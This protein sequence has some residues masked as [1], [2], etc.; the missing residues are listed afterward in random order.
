MYI[1]KDIET[2]LTPKLNMLLVNGRF[3]EPEADGLT[4]I[5]YLPSAE[6]EATIR[7]IADGITT[8]V[9]IEDNEQELG[10]S[11]KVV[12]IKNNINTFKIELVDEENKALE[13]NLIIKKAEA[14]ASIDKV[15]VSNGDTDIECK[16][17]ADGNYTVK[18]PRNYDNVDV[19]AIAKYPK[20]KVQI[21][22]TGNYIIEKDTQN[23]VLEDEQIQVK[24][25]VQSE[26][27]SNETECIL[28]IEKYSNNTEYSRSYFIVTD[29]FKNF[30]KE[31]EISTIDENLKFYDTDGLVYDTSAF[32]YLNEINKNFETKL[33]EETSPKQFLPIFINEEENV[34][35]I[36]VNQNN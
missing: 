28:T 2:E 30:V 31:H 12:E 14:D 23:I 27:S 33:V 10:D 18:V 22:E 19:T 11:E 5:T 25:M 32:I 8:K 9:Q 16:M 24:I 15:Y 34:F 26:D 35:I 6:Q 1:Y 17:L 20:A 36:T 4:Y 29:L 13:Y 7:A 21:A 3:V